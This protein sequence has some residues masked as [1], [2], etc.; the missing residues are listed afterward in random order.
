MSKL[1]YCIEYEDSKSLFKYK[2]CKKVITE[3]KE[4]DIYHKKMLELVIDKISMKSTCV[5][6]SA[7]ERLN[8][9]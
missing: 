5:K 1:K 7:K 6:N 4:C 3:E 9:P 2:I 8:T